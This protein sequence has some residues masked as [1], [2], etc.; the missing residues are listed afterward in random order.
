VNPDVAGSN[1]VSHPNSENVMINDANDF[2]REKKYKFSNDPID[3]MENTLGEETQ[4]A[5]LAAMRSCGDANIDREQEIGVFH[6]SALPYLSG[7]ISTQIKSYLRVFPK[8]HRTPG[9]SP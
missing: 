4:K 8:G 3:R 7:Y 2:P 6:L 9:E 1:P 5:I